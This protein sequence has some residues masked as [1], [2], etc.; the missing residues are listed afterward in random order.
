MKN[1]PDMNNIEEEWERIKEAITD[2][3]N[4]VIQIQ[5][6][7]PRNEWWDEECRQYIKKKNEVR[8]KWPQQNTTASQEA[9]KMRIEANVLIKRKKRAWAYN[10]ILQIEYNHKRNCKKILPRNKNL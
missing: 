5:S 8:S 6:R 4:K 9:Y 1:T 3:A 7:T 2:K 10:K